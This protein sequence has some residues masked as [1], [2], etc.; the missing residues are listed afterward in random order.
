MAR[1]KEEKKITDPHERARLK[2]LRSLERRQ[3]RKARKEAA[4][5]NDEPREKQATPDYARPMVKDDYLWI[6]KELALV[7][8]NKIIRSHGER[9]WWLSIK[10]DK[11]D[12]PPPLSNFYPCSTFRT[13]NGRM[14][15][16]FLFREH[17]D[18]F[19]VT[20]D[21]ARKE[22]ADRVRSINPSVLA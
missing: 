19:F 2:K 18:L 6:R 8:A 9:P 7:Y 14:Y 16:G 20:L 4:G 3:A 17:R 22:T 5:G 1:R 13:S 10:Y 11:D 12:G 15:Y 21:D